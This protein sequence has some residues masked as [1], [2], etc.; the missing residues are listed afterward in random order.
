MATVKVNLCQSHVSKRCFLDRTGPDVAVESDALGC[1]WARCVSRVACHV[2]LPG[3]FY[4]VLLHLARPTKLSRPRRHGL[5]GGVGWGGNPAW[6]NQ[7]LFLSTF[8]C[9][10]YPASTKRILPCFEPACLS[11]A[12]CGVCLLP[13]VLFLFFFLFTSWEIGLGCPTLVQYRHLI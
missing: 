13:W 11:F 10:L 8:F 1:K 9:V 6:C 7:F 4:L 3:C 12:R 2:P 5:R